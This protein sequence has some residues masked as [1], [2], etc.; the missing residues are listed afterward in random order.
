LFRTHG[1]D[2]GLVSIISYETATRKLAKRAPTLSVCYQTSLFSKKL[3][4][5]LTG[6]SLSFLGLT[7]G[8]L[9]DGIAS[10]LSA[11]AAVAANNPADVVRTRLYNQPFKVNICGCHPHSVDCEIM[12]RLSACI[13]APH[14]QIVDGVRVGE[15]Y[16]GMGQCAGAIFKT[17][18]LLAFW[19]GLHRSQPADEQ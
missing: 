10:M 1:K 9:T 11:F 17:E 8:V 12:Q 15:Y 6:R 3:S 4:D 5:F 18:G 14:C 16:S 2:L 7:T 13:F 19:K